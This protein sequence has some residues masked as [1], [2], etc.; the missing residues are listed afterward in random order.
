MVSM[1]VR[2]AN[3]RGVQVTAPPPGCVEQR[4]SALGVSLQPMSRVHSELDIP[5]APAAPYS[6]QLLL[7]M[8]RD[9]YL[10]FI[11]RMNT[12]EYAHEIR[13]QIEK[14]KVFYLSTTTREHDLLPLFGVLTNNPCFR[15]NVSQFIR[16]VIIGLTSKIPSVFL[17]NIT[18]SYWLTN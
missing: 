18:T 17:V 16:P 10:A 3:R 11:A 4:L 8:F 15:S 1:R 6:L 2:V 5:R 12:P 7:D 14:E 13:Q 9:Q